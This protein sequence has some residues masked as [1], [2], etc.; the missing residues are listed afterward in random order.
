ML[1]EMISL[2]RGSVIT[3]TDNPKAKPISQMARNNVFG[4]LV[5]A[6]IPQD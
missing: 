5:G 3:T 4:I 1:N 6:K 2:H